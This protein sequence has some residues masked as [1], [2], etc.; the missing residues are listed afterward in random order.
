[1]ATSPPKELQVGDFVTHRKQGR[2]LVVRLY[3]GTIPSGRKL[4]RLAV[5]AQPSGRRVTVKVADLQAG[6]WG[7]LPPGPQPCPEWPDCSDD[8]GPCF[9][10]AE[11]QRYLDAHEDAHDQE[12]EHGG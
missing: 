6:R 5:L 11:Y 2:C 12:N 9:A 10:C 8:E 1:M 7:Y 4:H 3:D